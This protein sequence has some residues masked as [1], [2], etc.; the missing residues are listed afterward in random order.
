MGLSFKTKKEEQEYKKWK[1]ENDIRIAK[2]KKLVKEQDEKNRIKKEE[3]KN[4]ETM[5]KYGTLQTPSEQ[6]KFHNPTL[7]NA[8]GQY[9]PPKAEFGKEQPAY[10]ERAPKKTPAQ[11]AFINS[12]SPLLSKELPGFFN[13]LRKPAST[14]MSSGLEQMFGHM[15]NPIL[16]GFLNPSMGQNNQVLFPSQLAQQGN[17]GLE[18]LMGQLA[19]QF[20]PQGLNYASENLPAAYEGLKGLGQ[21]GLQ[22]G[23]QA[24][25][26]IMDLLSGLVNKFRTPQQPQG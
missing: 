9:S 20:I 3:A 24:G 17:P 18:N 15:Q 5:E 22:Y 7:Y 11:E 26:N 21:Q 4:K 13:E 23:Q 12:L 6:H 10:L 2:N 19:Q 16:Q 1:R 14:S 25:G 8:K